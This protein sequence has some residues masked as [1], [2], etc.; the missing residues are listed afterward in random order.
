MREAYQYAHDIEQLA[1]KKKIEIFHPHQGNYYHVN[2]EKLITILG[3]GKELYLSLIQASGK[4]PEMGKF[5]SVS[6]SFGTTER[7]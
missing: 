7:K 5:E 3:P 2:D 4:T 6:K 1:I